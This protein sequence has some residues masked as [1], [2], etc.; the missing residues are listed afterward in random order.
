MVFQVVVP[1]QLRGFEIGRHRLEFVYQ[2]P[3]VFERLNRKQWLSSL[4]SDAGYAKVAS[5]LTVA[6]YFCHRTNVGI[7]RGDS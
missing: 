3:N 1:K 6:G 4:K 5:S 2:T 7:T